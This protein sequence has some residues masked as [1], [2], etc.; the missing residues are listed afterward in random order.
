[1]SSM[2]YYQTHTE[3]FNNLINSSKLYR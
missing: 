1:M 3:Q 2:I